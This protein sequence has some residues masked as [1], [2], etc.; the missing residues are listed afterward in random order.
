MAANFLPLLLVGGAA[1]YVVTQDKKKKDKECPPTTTITLGELES[2]M[3]QAREKFGEAADP[4]QEASFIVNG[5]LP[6]G[7]S[8]ASKN[9]EFKIQIPEVEKSWEISIPNAYMFSFMG[10]LGIRKESGKISADQAQKFWVRELG[11]Y[12]SVT[13]KNFDVHSSGVLELAH[14]LGDAI[15]KAMEDSGL[16]DGKPKPAPSN[17]NGSGPL[18]DLASCPANFDWDVDEQEFIKM[19]QAHALGR[20]M[21]PNDPFKAADVVFESVVM[22]GCT[23]KDYESTVTMKMVLPGAPPDATMTL[24]LAALYAMFVLEAGDKM[25][26]GPAKTQALESKVASNYQQLTG[27]PLAL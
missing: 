10:T 1:A 15:K 8:R 6:K 18:P 23:K 11:W 26:L 5:L 25:N 3:A 9:S 7:C 4:S 12:K 20:Q 24:D 27:K 16:M 22:P 17:G 19:E 13:G 2:V 14:I 21:H